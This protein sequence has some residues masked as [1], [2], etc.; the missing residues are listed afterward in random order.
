M[1]AEIADLNGEALKFVNEEKGCEFARRSARRGRDIIAERVNEDAGQDRL[2][3]A[4]F[5]A[6][7]L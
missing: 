5:T 3:A 6:K 2:S 1:D 4:C 7:A